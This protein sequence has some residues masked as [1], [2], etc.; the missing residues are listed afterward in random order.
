MPRTIPFSMLS[1]H[2][3]IYQIYFWFS[4]GFLL[5]STLSSVTLKVCNWQLSLYCS[6]AWLDSPGF[7][8]FFGK[9]NPS[10]CKLCN[11]KMMMMGVCNQCIVKQH[12]CKLG[13]ARIFMVIVMTNLKRL[14]MGCN[15]CAIVFW[16]PGQWSQRMFEGKFHFI[17]LN[18]NYP[19]IKI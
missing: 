4:T 12:K 9:K 14:W 5:N 19:K 11:I 1:G 13:A 16:W 18:I 10:L 6:S 2:L 7:P 17:L 15:L 8:K 3:T